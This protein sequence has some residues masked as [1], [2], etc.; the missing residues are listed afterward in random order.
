MFKRSSD[1]VV[2]SYDQCK[3]FSFRLVT[4]VVMNED[5]WVT[6]DEIISFK[7]T[8]ILDLRLWHSSLQGACWTS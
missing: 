6:L 8:C 3:F 2:F 1:A 4:Y 7:K 5:E